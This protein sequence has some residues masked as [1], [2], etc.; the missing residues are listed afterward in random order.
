MLENQRIGILPLAEKQVK[1]LLA[2]ASFGRNAK[3]NRQA[4]GQRQLWC[5]PHENSLNNPLLF[6]SQL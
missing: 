1:A 6:L 4:S 5:S 3:D 2:S